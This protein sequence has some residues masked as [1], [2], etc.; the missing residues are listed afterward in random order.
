[1][2]E[3]EG[4]DG[5]AEELLQ[6]A[7]IDADDAAAVSLKVDG[8]ALSDALTVIFHGRRDLGTIQTYVTPGGRGAGD[9]V[10]ASELLRVPCDLDLS[11]AQDRA[12]A[13]ELYAEQAGVLRD[14]IVAADTVLSIWL[15]PL[16]DVAGE[17]FAVRS[18]ALGV[19]APAPRLMPVALTA[20]DRGITIIPVCGARTLAEGRPPLGIACT[21]QDVA[22]IYPLPDD[23]E[24]CLEDFAERAAEAA[25]RLAD[26]LSHQEASVE[27]FLELSEGFPETG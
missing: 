3:F 7:L 13:S 18:V 22:Q 20:P 8:L 21:Q 11:D 6:R 10:S 19:S 1:M 24:R 26:Q 14:A 23:P 12:E 25:R 4:H 15:E 2:Q 9:A 16:R 17:V 27:R 5:D